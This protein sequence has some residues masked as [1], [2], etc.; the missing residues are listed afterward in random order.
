[1][2]KD[3]AKVKE[4]ENRI[5]LAEATEEAWKAYEEALRACEETWRA[6][7]KA[8]LKHLPEIDALHKQECPDCP[9]DGKT[10]FT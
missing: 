5:K 2:K 9:W 3:K 6:H 7:D 8:I 4:L 1:M 10:I